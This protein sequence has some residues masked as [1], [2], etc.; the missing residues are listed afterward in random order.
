MEH[1]VRRVTSNID[2]TTTFALDLKE[3]ADFLLAHA[4]LPAPIVSTGGPTWYVW[5]G[6]DGRTIAQEVDHLRRQIGGTWTKND[7]K[8][9]SSTY[10]LTRE[11]KLGHLTIDIQANRNDVCEKVQTGVKTLVIPAAPA[12]EEHVIE[13]PVF[14]WQC[15]PLSTHANKLA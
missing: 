1:G 10:M 13:E 6:N 15:I 9:N 8:N 5:W 2:T 14:E 7:P 12:T 4:E 11:E 3:L